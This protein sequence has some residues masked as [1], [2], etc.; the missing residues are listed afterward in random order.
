MSQVLHMWLVP[1]KL[2]A[3]H[4]SLVLRRTLL[5]RRTLPVRRTLAECIPPEEQAACI[6]RI[7]PEVLLRMS[8]ELHR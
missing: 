3:L 1:H 2:L 6:P 5:V 4:M 7:P 8:L